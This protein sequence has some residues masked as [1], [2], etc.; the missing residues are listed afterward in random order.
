MKLP[1]KTTKPDPKVLA[2]A[3]SAG[4]ALGAGLAVAAIVKGPDLLEGLNVKL[5]SALEKRAG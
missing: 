1:R 3:V 2:G 5:A 4:L